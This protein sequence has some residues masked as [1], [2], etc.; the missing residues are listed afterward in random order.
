MSG[1]VCSARDEWACS[2]MHTKGRIQFLL[3]EFLMD[4]WNNQE[5]S[6]NF[7]SIG[8]AAKSR[9]LD[10]DLE[11]QQTSSP[12]GLKGREREIEVSKL[13]RACGGCLGAQRR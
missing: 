8:S 3:R 9:D 12:K 5:L 1:I 7:V 11:F 13:L 4:S 2:L 6:S 10:L